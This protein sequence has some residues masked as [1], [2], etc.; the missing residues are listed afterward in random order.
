MKNFITLGKLIRLL[1]SLPLLV[2]LSVNVHTKN[3]RYELARLVMGS[4]FLVGER[5]SETLSGLF[6]RDII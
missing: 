3:T 2:L 4:I 6:N 1:F 5:V